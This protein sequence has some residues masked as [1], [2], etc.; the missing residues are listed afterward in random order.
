MAA[1]VILIGL[2]A[3]LPSPRF[4]GPKA[5]LTAALE[6]ERTAG[7]DI[8]R[9]LRRQ[10]YELEPVRNLQNAIFDSYTRHADPFSS[11]FD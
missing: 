11:K 9:T 8:A 2:G 1:P 3:N 10:K 7:G 6:R 5:T 4:G